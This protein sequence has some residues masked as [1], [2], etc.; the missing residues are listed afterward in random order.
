V[1]GFASGTEV[2]AATANELESRR[3]G[4]MNPGPNRVDKKTLLYEEI[5]EVA[6]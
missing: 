5:N 3:A 6:I 2:V 1:G 4:R